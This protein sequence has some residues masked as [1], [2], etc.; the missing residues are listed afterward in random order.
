MCLASD[1]VHTKTQETQDDIKR[2][3]RYN[4]QELSTKNQ[5]TK[6]KNLQCCSQVQP[7]EAPSIHDPQALRSEHLS[8]EQRFEPYDKN[9]FRL[10]PG[11]SR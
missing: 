6:P 10:E 8:D 2:I 11:K 7:D 1:F 9:H 4:N 3:L 5:T